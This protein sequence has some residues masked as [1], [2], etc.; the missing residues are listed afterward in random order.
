M[1]PTLKQ[2][3][4]AWGEPLNLHDHLENDLGLDSLERVEF[5]NDVAAVLNIGKEMQTPFEY[6]DKDG[7]KGVTTVLI[8]IAVTSQTVEDV[9]NYV[10]HYTG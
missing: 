8:M 5:M 9:I 6:E 7:E 10:R 4:E 2:I 3:S 1:T